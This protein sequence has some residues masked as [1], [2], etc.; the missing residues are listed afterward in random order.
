MRMHIATGDPEEAHAWLRSAYVDHTA[1]LSGSRHAFRFSHRLADCG[2]FKVGVAQHTMDLHGLWDPLDDI[3]LF[4]HLLS[5]RFTIRSSRAEV[6]AGAG[7]V[8]SYDPDAT[9][10]VDWSDIRMAQ[11]RLQRSAAERLAAELLGDDRAPTRITF[12]LARPAT[13][14]KAL[15]WKQLMRY[16]TSDVAMNPGAYGSPLV[17]RQVFRLIVAAA[18]ETFPNTAGDDVRRAPGPASS[19]AIRRATAFIE[20]RAGADIDLTDIADAAHVGPRALQR[21]FRRSLDTTPLGYLR[22]VRMDRAHDELRAADPADGATV[23]RVAAR[24]GFGHPGRFATAY[25]ARFG[26]LPSNTLRDD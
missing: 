15:H 22:G 19:G 10:T 3:L 16:V 26:R 13:E 4:S 25:R 18:L 24:W 6:A 9:M 7:D 14:A 17:V 5:G 23:A 12:D 20:E 8:F 2:A 21:A 1:Q 11:V